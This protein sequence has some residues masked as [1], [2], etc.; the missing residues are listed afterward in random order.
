M[1]KTLIFLFTTLIFVATLTA[2]AARPVLKCCGA[3]RYEDFTD[4]QVTDGMNIHEKTQFGARVNGYY[5]GYD[6]RSFAIIDGELDVLFK[7]NIRAWLGYQTTDGRGRNSVNKFSNNTKRC[8]IE[9]CNKECFCWP[10]KIG[11]EGYFMEKGVFDT[12][13]THAELGS[14]S[15]HIG[16]ITFGSINGHVGYVCAQNRKA[17][18]LGLGLHRYFSLCNNLNLYLK[19]MA[20]HEQLDGP[21]NL[22]NRWYAVI[23]GDIK[24][25]FNKCSSIHLAGYLMPGGIPSTGTPLNAAAG[26]AILEPSDLVQKLKKNCFGLISLEFRLR[27]Q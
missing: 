18:V 4:Y 23:S 15:S 14:I 3:T 27:A 26:F 8:G 17:I 11:Y 16:E 20:Y 12:S 19:G 9:Y 13:N 21:I 25:C 10:V 1:R 2:D 5:L 7:E 6:G 22:E 24:Y